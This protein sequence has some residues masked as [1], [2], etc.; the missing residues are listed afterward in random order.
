MDAPL[1]VR[2]LLFAQSNT[3]PPPLHPCRGIAWAYV[4]RHFT[5][6]A[7]KGGPAGPTAAVALCVWP[8]QTHA[9]NAQP[10]GDGDGL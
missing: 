3:P 6:H 8:M 5:Q 1:L 2:A 7:A 10:G 4:G 9:P